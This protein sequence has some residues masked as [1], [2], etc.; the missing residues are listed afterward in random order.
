MAFWPLPTILLHHSVIV[1]ILT[2]VLQYLCMCIPVRKES[3][4]I[5]AENGDTENCVFQNMIVGVPERKVLPKWLVGKAKKV[6]L[7]KKK[8]GRS[9]SLTVGKKKK[10]SLICGG[11]LLNGQALLVLTL[12]QFCSSTPFDVNIW[13]ERLKAMGIQMTVDQWKNLI[14][15]AVLKPE[16]SKYLFYNSRALGITITVGPGGVEKDMG[17]CKHNCGMGKLDQDFLGPSSL[18]RT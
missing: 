7:R 16:V 8:P 13:I 9:L 10:N 5:H 2:T 3:N 15:H 11:K 1:K 12:P 14:Q 18:L 4:S 6:W 17:D